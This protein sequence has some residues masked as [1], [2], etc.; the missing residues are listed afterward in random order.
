MDRMKLAENLV[1]LVPYMFKRFMKAFHNDNMPKN[2]IGLLFHVMHDSGKS[3]SYYSEKMMMPKSNLSV[4][5]ESLIK[6]GLLQRE[7]DENDRRIINLQ[8]TEEGRKFIC[9]YKKKVLE[10]ADRKLSVLSDEDI[11]RLDEIVIEMRTIINKLK[12]E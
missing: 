3:M 9:E 5:A 10:E 8:V 4:A 12:Q 6:E 7:F 1:T 2:N 11:K